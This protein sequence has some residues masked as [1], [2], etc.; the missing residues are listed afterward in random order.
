MPTF[1]EWENT[2]LNRSYENIDYLSLHRYYGN[3]DN[4]TPN[5]LAKSKDLDEFI[6]GV[7]AICDAVK[8]RKHS[9]KQVNLSLDE[10]NIWYH[11]KQK[12]EENQPWQKSPHL[13]EDIYNFEDALL[14]GSLLI[15]ILKHSDRVKI[16]CL[17]QLVNVIAPIM[18]KND[19]EA[20]I[21]PI[22]YPFMQVSNYGRGTVLTPIE[23]SP[24]YSS[25]DFERVPYLESIAVVNEE[26]NEVIIF[27][28]N[29]SLN[30]DMELKILSDGF[31]FDR[32]IEATE[33][34]GYALKQTNENGQMHI[35]ANNRIENG[36][37]TT[38]INLKPASWNMIRIKLS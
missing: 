2:V 6:A 10:W 22:F 26:K 20:W 38:T 27:A 30:E 31:D 29:K 14:I 18:T 37:Q 19:G 17:A 12:D 33:F 16:A 13:L 9:K 34:E 5:Y 23:Y 36:Q 3:E 11:S 24:T 4:D 35:R 32:V 25:K 21:Q 15:T 8:A 28:V 7:I 1:G